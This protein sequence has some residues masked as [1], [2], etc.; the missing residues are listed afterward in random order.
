MKKPYENPGV[1]KLISNKGLKLKLKIIIT[2]RRQT[3]TMSLAD[4][5]GY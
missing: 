2:S 4:Y 1:G 3:M 5:I